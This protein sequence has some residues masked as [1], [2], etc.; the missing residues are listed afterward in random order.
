MEM[1]QSGDGNIIEYVI[2]AV[3][4]MGTAVTG[5][6]GKKLAGKMDKEYFRLYLEQHDQLH[7]EHKAQHETQRREAREDAKEIKAALAVLQTRSNRSR[8]DD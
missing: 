1:P 5:L 6:F 7:K 3:A 4:A 2:A 8:G